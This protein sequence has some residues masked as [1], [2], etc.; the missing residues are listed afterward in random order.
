MVADQQTKCTEKEWN[1]DSVVQRKKELVDD[2]VD[3]R[4]VEHDFTAAGVRHKIDETIVSDENV[5][6]KGDPGD[7]ESID[8]SQ[9]QVR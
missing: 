8:R 1:N 4:R 9:D 6:T 5:R 2:Q 7:D 3:G